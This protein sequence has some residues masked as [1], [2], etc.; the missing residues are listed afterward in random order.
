MTFPATS[1][2]LKR[3]GF[4]YDNDGFCRRCGD[5]VEWWITPSGNK[6]PLTVKRAGPVLKTSA[7][8][9]ELHQAMCN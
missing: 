8:V 4:E 3:A 7:E 1:D 2:Q 6:I 5:P 9:R